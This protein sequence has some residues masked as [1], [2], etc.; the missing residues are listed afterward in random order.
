MTN[1]PANIDCKYIIG[2]TISA[3]VGSVG[4]SVAGILRT[5]AWVMNPWTISFG[6]LIGYL[7]YNGNI[8]EKQKDIIKEQFDPSNLPPPA[9]DSKPIPVFKRNYDCKGKYTYT[10]V[11][12]Y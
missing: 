5:G 10:A 1:D 6:A 4:V 11:S 12:H 9:P 7:W 8:S 3:A 2:A